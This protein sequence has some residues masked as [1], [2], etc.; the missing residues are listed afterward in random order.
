MSNAS[1]VGQLV[2]GSGTQPKQNVAWLF[3][4]ASHALLLA[5]PRAGLSDAEKRTLSSRIEQLV[6]GAP[7][8]GV[9]LGGLDSSQQLRV[10]VRGA[11]VT[12][13]R[14]RPEQRAGR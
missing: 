4:D 3:P 12:R 8:E 13:N 9:G 11:D 7:L 10:L 2:F 1:F 5:R 6:R 14:D